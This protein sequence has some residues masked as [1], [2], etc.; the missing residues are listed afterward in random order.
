ML[1][2]LLILLTVFLLFD[3]QA[4]NKKIKQIT[5]KEYYPSGKLSMIIVEDFDTSGLQTKRS[6]YDGGKKPLYLS[7]SVYDTTGLLIKETN[8]D[9]RAETNDVWEYFY[10]ERRDLIRQQRFYSDTKMLY[11]ESYKLTYNA[12]GLEISNEETYKD[13]SKGWFYKYEYDSLNNMTNSKSHFNDTIRTE[14]AYTYSGKLKTSQ[15]LYD[16]ENKKMKRELSE[17]IYYTYIEDRVAT[18]TVH[19]V[20]KHLSKKSISIKTYTYD[21]NNLLIL[22]TYTIDNVPQDKTVYEYVFY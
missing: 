3:L 11:I 6:V 22:E 7:V 16:Y 17:M 9:K 2:T 1:R 10:N 19:S 20:A 14:Y 8:Y 18:R 4:Q 15:F 12:K 13:G 5:A 21:K